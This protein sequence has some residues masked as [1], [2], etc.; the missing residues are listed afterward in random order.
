MLNKNGVDWGDDY[1]SSTFQYGDVIADIATYIAQHGEGTQFW[2]NNVRGK[3]VMA[4]ERGDRTYAKVLAVRSD[5]AELTQ[6]EVDQLNEL[7]LP[8][9]KVAL[10][11]G[12]YKLFYPKA[13][14]EGMPFEGRQWNDS[15]ADCYRLVLDYYQKELSLKLPVVVTPSNYVAQMQSYAGVNLFLTN[16]EMSGFHQVMFPQKHDVIYIRSGNVRLDGPDHCAIYLDDNK[17]LHHYRHRL[18]VIQEWAGLWRQNT[19]MIL[20]HNSFT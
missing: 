12:Q 16:W 8:I 2:L 9:L 5:T 3:S 20:R 13:Y 19:V 6:D 18:S 17:I 4:A 7:G 10:P 11:Y 15:T 1:G 14:E